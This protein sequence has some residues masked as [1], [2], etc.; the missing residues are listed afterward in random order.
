M[1]ERVIYLNGEYV[2]ESSAKVSVL[3]RGFRWGDAVYDATR[4]FD[5]RLFNGLA[6]GDGRPGPIVGKLLQAWSQL[7][8]IDVVEQATRHA[9]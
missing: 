9:R 3:D 1:A 2:A 5:G 8:G 6:L 4:T 7:V